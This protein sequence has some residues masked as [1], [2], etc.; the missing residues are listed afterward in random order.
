MVVGCWW[1]ET[2]D[3]KPETFPSTLDSL[4]AYVSLVGSCADDYAVAPE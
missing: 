2:K 4:V 1:M 3:Q